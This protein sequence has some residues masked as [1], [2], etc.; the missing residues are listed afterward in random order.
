[1]IVM[2]LLLS[3]MMMM[4]KRGMNCAMLDRA[5]GNPLTS[6]NCPGGREKSSSCTKTHNVPTSSLFQ[7]QL[8]RILAH[9]TGSTT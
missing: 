1:M 4:I 6:N 8:G 9:A 7:Q 2:L 3:L 5:M